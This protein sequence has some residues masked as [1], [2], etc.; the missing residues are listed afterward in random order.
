MRKVIEVRDLRKAY[1]S[2]VAVDGISF[3]VYEGEIFG[4]VGPNGAGKTTTIE[5]LEGLRRPDSG[6][7]RVL[8]LD[9]WRQGQRLRERIGIQLQEG[10]LPERLRVEEALRLFAA[11]YPRP[12]S[13]EALLRRLGLA[14]HRRQAFGQLSGGLRQRLFIALALIG[15]PQLLFLDELTTGLDPH[16]RRA[17]WD[18][19]REIRAEGRTVFLTT[20]YMEEAERLCDRVAIVDRGRLVALDT[21]ENLIRSLGAEGRVIFTLEAAADL[22]FLAGLPEV[23]R[24]ERNGARVIVYGR[25]DRLPARILEALTQRGISPLDLRVERPNLEDVFLKLTGRPM[26]TS[27]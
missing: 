6:Q 20:H 11:F 18:L 10:G 25:D 26:E 12:R 3:E 27:G 2:R 21:P 24:V 5:C 19:V 8:G 1:G 7:I 23:L 9:P 14:E 16:A 4:M 15:D 17:M 22:S 13:P